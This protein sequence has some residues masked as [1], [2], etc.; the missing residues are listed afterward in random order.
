VALFEDLPECVVYYG[1][2]AE[3]LRYAFDGY[4]IMGRADAAGGK[5]I[6]VCFRKESDFARYL[7]GKIGYYRDAADINAAGPKLFGEK[8]KS[9]NP[10]PSRSESRPR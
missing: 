8:K 9:W 6:V 5:D 4:I 10:V 1:V 3:G 7:I 2:H